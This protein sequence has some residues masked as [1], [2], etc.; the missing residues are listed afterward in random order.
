MAILGRRGN[1]LGE[2]DPVAQVGDPVVLIPRCRRAGIRQCR[3]IQGNL[4]WASRWKLRGQ[5]TEFPGE[6]VHRRTVKCHVGIDPAHH[7]AF[8]RPD[9]RDL[10][11]GV[12][13]AGHHR[14]LRGGADRRDHIGSAAQSLVGISERQPHQ[15]HRPVAHHG[16]E[17]ARPVARHRCAHG[18]VEN[19]RRHARGDLPDRVP[20]H[21]CGRHASCAQHGRETHLHRKRQGLHAVCATELACGQRLAGAETQLAAEHRIDRVDDRG[22]RGLTFEQLLPHTGPVRSVTGEHPDR[23]FCAR[24][25][26]AAGHDGRI[27]VIVGERIQSCHHTVDVLG[28]HGSPGRFVRAARPRRGRHTIESVIAGAQMVGQRLG[29][30]AQPGGGPRRYRHHRRRSSHAVGGWCLRRRRLLEQN[31]GDRAAVSVTAHRGATRSA[32]CALPWLHRRRHPQ[33]AVRP[34]HSGRK[35]FQAGRRRDGLVVQGQRR[36][37]EPDHART[38]LQVADVR[39]HRADSA[40]RVRGAVG[41]VDGGQRPNLGGVPGRCAGSVRLDEVDAHGCDTR[42]FACAREHVGLG[43]AVRRHDAHCAAIL[44]D[45]APAHEG[46]HPVTVASRVGK[47]LE[48]HHGRALTTPVA[49]GGRVECLAPPIRR[50]GPGFVEHPGQARADQRADTTGE[51]KRRLTGTQHLACLMHRDERCGARGVQRHARAAKIEEMRNPVGD[52]AE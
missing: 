21:R 23:A 9:L 24:G 12:H 38:A 7:H 34:I 13:R 27:G 10:S 6:R 1:R 47:A 40:R 46:D 4:G 49:V 33:T 50:G 29:L 44:R 28:H 35:S 15:C 43:V 22:E 11:D 16:P 19:T 2:S 5:S 41:P 17:A 51:G 30:A 37:D 14:R 31:V 3:C 26:R 45:R 36:L 48:H 20:D 52:P 8:V 39:L 32:V 42:R 18:Q 25:K